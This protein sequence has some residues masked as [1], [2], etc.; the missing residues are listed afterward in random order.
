MNKYEITEKG[1]GAVYLWAD[2]ATEAFGDYL[3]VTPDASIADIEVKLVE[4]GIKIHCPEDSDLDKAVQAGGFCMQNEKGTKSVELHGRIGPK[5]EVSLFNQ[6]GTFEGLALYSKA[7]LL[8]WF[9]IQVFDVNV[10]VL[11]NF[12]MEVGA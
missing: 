2:N 7:Q 1:L 6:N 5:Y 11:S 10:E 4:E 8:R 9:P 12:G 3:V